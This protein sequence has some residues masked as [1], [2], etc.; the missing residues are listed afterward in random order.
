LL[1]AHLFAFC[2]LSSELIDSLAVDGGGVS[3]SL[4]SRKTLRIRRP[5]WG[6][7]VRESARVFHASR[8]FRS[9]LQAALGRAAAA[10]AAAFWCLRRLPILNIALNY[11]WIVIS[12]FCNTEMSL[13]RV[14]LTAA[15]APLFTG[16]RPTPAGAAPFTGD[17]LTPAGTPPITGGPRGRATGFAPPQ[18]PFEATRR[19]S[20]YGLRFEIFLTVRRLRRAEVRVGSDSA[21]PMSNHFCTSRPKIFFS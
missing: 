20:R 7:A 19:R 14:A 16:G 12:P 10:V 11:I 21:M 18:A 8:C 3:S 17:R 13:G 5:P 1:C 6:L 2:G 4:I 9:D 15:R